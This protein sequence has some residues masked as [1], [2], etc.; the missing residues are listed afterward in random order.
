MFRFSF[1]IR[2]ELNS[3]EILYACIIYRVRYYMRVMYNIVFRETSKKAKARSEIPWATKSLIR[4]GAA[5]ESSTNLVTRPRWRGRGHH[6]TQLV[7]FH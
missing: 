1:K 5:T 6:L 2:T 4:K 3:L 7:V